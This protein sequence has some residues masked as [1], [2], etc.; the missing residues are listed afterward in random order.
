MCIRPCNAAPSRGR[1]LTPLG[2]ICANRQPHQPQGTAPM[3]DAVIAHLTDQRDAILERLKALLRLPSVSTDPAFADAMQSAREFLLQRLRDDRHAE[4]AVAG[5]RRPA[6]GVRRVA[7]RARPADADRLRPLRRAAGRSAGTVGLAAVR[8]HRARRPPVRPRRVGREGLH[9]HRGRNDRRLPGG[10]RRL[11][12]EHQAVHRRRGG[13]AAAP[14]CATSSSAIAT[15]S[16]ADAMLSADG[17]RASTTVPTLGIGG[18]GIAGLQFTL[19]TARRTRI[20]A[21][22]AVRCATHCTRWRR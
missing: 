9:H 16:T 7:W 6:G 20:P 21:A 3:S 13:N 18:R 2:L 17:G 4:R 10:D 14:A 12:G 8:T 1:C 15:S 22:M 5:R 19:R 11:P